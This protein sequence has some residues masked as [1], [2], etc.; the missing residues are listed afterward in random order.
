M[1]WFYKFVTIKVFLAFLH[2]NYF[3]KSKNGQFKKC[4]KLKI[5][6]KFEQK[7]LKKL[8]Y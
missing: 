3:E 8:F 7:K 2:E 1:Y 6:K 5:L 4:P